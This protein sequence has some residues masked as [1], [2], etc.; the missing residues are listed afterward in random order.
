MQGDTVALR[1][2]RSLLHLSH[3]RS[4]ENSSK[5]TAM[6]SRYLL[7]I[8]YSIALGEIK[9]TLLIKRPA[10]VLTSGL[11]TEPVEYV[12]LLLRLV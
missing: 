5:G 9:P 3:L 2:N 6:V 1:S 10:K 12:C 4:A 7:T 8:E 11:H